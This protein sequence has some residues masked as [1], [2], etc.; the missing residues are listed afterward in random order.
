[1]GTVSQWLTGVTTLAI[2]ATA[3]ASPFTA[4]ILTSLFG[5]IGNVYQKAKK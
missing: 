3:V 4:P 2:F 1:M 5:G